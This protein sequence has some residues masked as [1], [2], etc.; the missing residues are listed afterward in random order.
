MKIILLSGGSGKRLWPLSNDTRSKQFLKLLRRSDGTYES[1]V[2]RVYRQIREAG[3][4]ASVTIATSVSQVDSIRSQLGNEVEIV[5][6]PE[7]RDTFPAIALATAYLVLER[8]C[9]PD[10]V[11]AV[12]PVDQYTEGS[13]FETVGRIAKAAREGVADLVLMGVKPTVPSPK[14][15]YIIPAEGQ[16]SSPYTV[17][18]FKEKPDEADACRLIEAGAF[19]NGGVFAFKAGYMME[20]VRRYSK[21]ENFAQLRGTYATLPKISFDYEVVEKARSVAMV[22]FSGVWE[23]LGTWNSLT[24]KMSEHVVG[25]AVTGEGTR[26]THVINELDV[27]VVVLGAHDM[28]ISASHDGILVS[29]KEA[30]SQLKSYVDNIHQRP[31]YEERRWGTYKVLDYKILEDG[32]HFLTKELRL[33]PGCSISYQ[34]HRLRK[35]IWTF[36]DGEG[37][38]LLDGEER[39]VSRGDTV[40]IKAGQKHAIK[41]IGGLCIIEVQLGKELVEEDIERF[42]TIDEFLK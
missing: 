27:P 2:Q 42:G 29:N 9:A 6:E 23:D 31:M 39:R 20:I 18:A 32:T 13:Y 24:G 15:G 33:N 21:A 16:L 40:S 26:N 30:S 11:V 3:M 22:P 19:W 41:A 37:I 17:K 14:Y 12:M 38:L 5:T 4:G 10:E 35:E 8:H 36:I 28:V 34:R 1:M 25:K 7:R